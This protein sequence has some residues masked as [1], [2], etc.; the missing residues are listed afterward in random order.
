MLVT[1]DFGGDELGGRT[2]QSLPSSETV[3]RQPQREFD[4]DTRFGGGF[5]QAIEGIEG[6]RD[7]GR[8]VDWFFY[9]NGMGSDEG[10]AEVELHDGDRVWWD[11][12]DWATAPHVSAV[13]G[14]FPEPFLTGSRQALPRG[15]RVH[16]RGGGLRD[17][18]RAPGGGRR[19]PRASARHRHGRETL[20]VLVGTWRQL[21]G[22]PALAQLDRGPTASGVFARFGDDAGRWR[23]ST[24]AATRAQ[25]RGGAGLVA[26]TRF[27]Q[28]APTWTITGTDAAGVRRPPRA[29]RA[30]LRRRFA[31]AVDPPTISP[32][33]G[34]LMGSAA[35]QPAPRCAR[36]GRMRAVR[37]ARAR[38]LLFDHP[39]VLAAVVLAAVAAG[40]AAGVG[41]RWP[42]RCC[43]RSV[44]A[45][46]GVI[47]PLV[48]REG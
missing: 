46:G 28:Q 15:A 38:A 43:W 21:R 18:L 40:V 20:R 48:A 26:A 17:G 4:V 45:G 24:P 31:L 13:V 22:D 14:S 33:R 6:G 35:G 3:M 37:R 5:V 39:L 36:R 44:R 2:V 27:E 32:C 10:A 25:P 11:H 41:R 12:H 34:A 23:C 47:N 42:S 7:D 9:V 1:R 16:R 30:G 19:V 8:P 29:R